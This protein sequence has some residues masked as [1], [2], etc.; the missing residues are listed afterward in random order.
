MECPVCNQSMDV[1]RT[2]TTHSRETKEEYTRTFYEC[3]KDNTWG[4]LETPKQRESEIQAKE[5]V[6][7]R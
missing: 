5:T 4:T 7:A 6:L 3:K 2:D 1:F